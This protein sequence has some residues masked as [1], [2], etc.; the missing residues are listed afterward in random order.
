MVKM[1]TLNTVHVVLNVKV[2]LELAANVFAFIV[3]FNRHSTQL[4]T[5]CNKNPD[6][7][8][9]TIHQSLEIERQRVTK[10]PQIIQAHNW[11]FTAC[12]D[13]IL[14]VWCIDVCQ[15]R[16]CRHF[17][18]ISGN[19]RKFL[20]F[21]KSVVNRQWFSIKSNMKS[22]EESIQISEHVVH[23]M[24]HSCITQQ[25]QLSLFQFMRF[26]LSFHAPP[27]LHSF[28]SLDL[29]FFEFIGILSFPY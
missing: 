20:S 21:I 8:W 11:R 22:E 29:F 10:K 14:Q 16:I 18:F 15:I 28:I 5:F 4:K 24:G 6:I 23:C 1:N 26:Y 2:I 3:H 9:I 13:G 25:S 17:H 27:F 12:F 19:R 7:S